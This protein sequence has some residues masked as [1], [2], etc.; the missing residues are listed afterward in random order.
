MGNGH[1][2]VVAVATSASQAEFGRRHR[3][4]SHQNQKGRSCSLDPTR[5][6]GFLL[7]RH[8]RARQWSSGHEGRP[9][10]QRQW[11]SGQEGRPST[12]LGPGGPIATT[13]LRSQCLGFTRK[14]AVADGP[15]FR[16]RDCVRAVLVS[17]GKGHWLSLFPKPV[18]KLFISRVS[19]RRTHGQEKNTAVII[20]RTRS[21]C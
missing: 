17:R 21:L 12:L 4:G 20:Q 14:S 5:P 11:S 7:V 1:A 9:Q 19:F 3:L 16:L 15:V 8:S 13:Q 2:T 10:V 18:S 6:P